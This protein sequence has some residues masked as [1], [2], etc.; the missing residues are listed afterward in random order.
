MPKIAGRVIASKIV[1]GKFLAKIALNGRLLPDGVNV[2]IKWGKSRSTAQ[3]ALYWLF[4]GYLW[5]ECGLKDEYS[6]VDELHETFKATFLSK[7]VFHGGKEFIKVGS[8]TSLGKVEFG[9][10]IERI[11]KA[12]IEYHGID[13]SGF[14]QEYK[15][16][17]DGVSME[18]TDEGRKWQASQE[19]A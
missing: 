12:M 2:S 7:R 8:T 18:L 17:K 10:Y 3:N 15:D 14:W 16:M 9:E 11:N 13:T 19:G 1:D 4:L 6:T 5:Q